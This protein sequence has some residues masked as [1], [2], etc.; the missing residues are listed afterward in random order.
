MT[1]PPSTNPRSTLRVFF[2]IFV[3]QHGGN[4][5]LRQRPPLG[6]PEKNQMSNPPRPV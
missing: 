5:R 3:A 4:G 1:T 2:A 6:K